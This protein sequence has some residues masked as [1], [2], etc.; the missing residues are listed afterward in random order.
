MPIGLTCQDPCKRES[1]SF[2][3]ESTR[4][5]K[6]RLGPNDHDLCDR[7][8]LRE[9]WYRVPQKGN[10]ATECPDVLRCGSLYPVWLNGTLPE[11]GQRVT[12]N[13]CQRGF[14]SC[15]ESTFKVEAQNC[16]DF[17]VFYLKPIPACPG[18]YCT[19]G[20]PAPCQPGTSSETG[21]E[22]CQRLHITF[23]VS[24]QVEPFIPTFDYTS[25]LRNLA[26]KCQVAM[27]SEYRQYVFDISWHINKNEVSYKSKISY[28][29]LDSEA[30][31]HGKD[32][33]AHPNGPKVLG[34]WVTC[35][36]RARQSAD[37]VPTAYSNSEDFFAGVQIEETSFIVK[38][39][40]TVNINIKSTVP[41][42]CVDA[43][44]GID[45][46][47]QIEL[48]SLQDQIKSRP[49]NCNDSLSD[50]IIKMSRSS[51]GLPFNGTEWQKYQTFT[52][53]TLGDEAVRPSYTCTAK[54]IA[55]SNIDYL[56]KDYQLPEV[57][58]HVLNEYRPPEMCFSVNDPH[59]TTFDGKY[60]TSH[61]TG[62]FV[63]F[64]HRTKPIEIHTIQRR[65]DRFEYASNCAII[66]RASTDMFVI[67]GCNKPTR[68]IARRL[69]CKRAHQ[70]LEVLEKGHEYEVVLP[71]GTR[72]T[73]QVKEFWLNIAIA[74]SSLDWKETEGLC[75][76]YN[77]QID[78]DF[79]N[80]EGNIVN[81]TEFMNSW[82][83]ERSQS[84]FV[85]KARTEKMKT[86]TLYCTC[87]DES[88]IEEIHEEIQKTADCTWKDS[89]PLCKPVNWKENTCQ[90]YGRTKREIADDFEFDVP[91]DVVKFRE[92]PK[93]FKWKNG[94]NEQKAVNACESYFEKSK[95]FKLC[96]KIT[97][98]SGIDIKT[99][100]ADIQI[101]GSTVF[102]S[103]SLDSMKTACIKEIRSN[104]SFW[105]PKPELKLQPT[106]T[107]E[108]NLQ[109]SVSKQS[110]TTSTTAR[111]LEILEYEDISILDIAETV[112]N[113][114]CPNDC[115]DSGICQHGVC[116]CENGFEGEDCSVDRRKGPEVFGLIKE[117]F[118][119]LSKRPCSFISVFGNGFYASERVK[120]RITG[121]TIEQN[122]VKPD[123]LNVTTEGSLITFAEVKCPLEQTDVNKSQI[124]P[125]VDAYLVAVSFDDIKYS[126]GSPIIVY[127]STC[128]IC[129]DVKGTVDCKMRE[130]VCIIERKCYR[131]KHK[132]CQKHKATESS[133]HTYSSEILYLGATL[134]GLG[135]VVVP[136]LLLMRRW[137][138]D[139]KRNIKVISINRDRLRVDNQM[140]D[141]ET[142]DRVVFCEKFEEQL[143]KTMQFGKYL[144]RVSHF[145]QIDINTHFVCSKCLQHGHFTSDCPND[146]MCRG[147]NKS[148]H[149]LINCP[150]FFENMRQKETKDQQE[151]ENQ[152]TEPDNIMQETTQKE[153]IEDITH[154]HNQEVNKTDGCTDLSIQLSAN[155][156]QNIT[157][158]TDDKQNL[159]PEKK[160]EK[161]KKNI[162][163][164]NESLSHSAVS[165][166]NNSGKQTSQK[167]LDINRFTTLNR[168][169]ENL[170]GRTPPTPPSQDKE[171]KAAKT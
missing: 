26:F 133:R 75:G 101:S 134:G 120:C 48:F 97:Q 82:K 168:R 33:K 153:H 141:C 93:E 78:D 51:C 117:S 90:N 62:E 105:K 14:L 45:C 96:S 100:V 29:Q 66:V 91:L 50:D 154:Q 146:W 53:N 24:P 57:S 144:A 114:D 1:Y 61:D 161:K 108:Q 35:S 59:L 80:R 94:W 151:K 137:W 162:P 124:F 148:G 85:A 171:N 113:N 5:V 159:T 55:K 30:V 2:L 166:T 36:M 135:I 147:C 136:T 143:P 8:L 6:Y 64:R 140:T 11:Q 74:V 167:Q 129:K 81:Q 70:F 25:E 13:G 157:V 121:A 149:K 47:I 7:R 87:Y 128:T 115:S 28:S 22:P 65:D 21:F 127:D 31:L 37:D 73:V 40:E 43:G 17:N 54:L 69:N 38:S 142:G 88:F 86:E 18:R 12:L 76:T 111:N 122:E 116:Q 163:E 106:T 72:I 130:D 49:A 27:P 19:V 107:P 152:I 3:N 98:P 16:N 23:S 165:K 132:M 71:T 15:C 123:S 95:L 77:Y 138:T 139:T 155:L 63:L 103:A 46:K 118:C 56:W 39:G 158:T 84:L 131:K 125:V 102:L 156:E 164:K 52:L 44:A 60:F 9:G 42:T 99:C 150:T 32:W 20:P 67:Y 160:K 10:I 169:Q 41:V 34:F 104:T 4:S 112:F 110:T 58:I 109:E 89:L 126:T 145:G 170:K 79:T 92:G 68:W 83:V 119:D